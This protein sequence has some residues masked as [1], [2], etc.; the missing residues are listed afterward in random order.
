MGATGNVGQKLVELL[1][2]H[3]W[4]DIVAVTASERSQNKK[5]G[6]AMQ[7]MM[8]SSLPPSVANLPVLPCLPNLPCQ[9]VFSALDSSVAGDIEW[10]FAQAGYAIISN[11]RNHRMHP[12]VPLLIP[13][14]NGEHLGLIQHQTH[15]PGMIVTNPNC[16]VIGLAT[17]LKPLTQICKIEKVHAVTL[18]AV[19]G[20]GYPGLPSVDILDNVIPYIS[21]EEEKVQ[22]EPL[23]ILGSI[24]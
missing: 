17:A 6:D 23:K 4:F 19:S 18:Q 15:A 9:I 12:D 13:E 1:A 24:S 16:S 22:T 8:P 10:L 7:W 3:P 14:V 20:A 21:G 5:Y 2:H 11:S